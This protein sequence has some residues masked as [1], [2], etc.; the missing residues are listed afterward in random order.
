MREAA[1]VVAGNQYIATR[2]RKAGAKSVKILP[3]VVDLDRYPL[4]PATN[5]E[6]F[7]IGWIG[8]PT[9]AYNLQ[10]VRPALEAFC[11]SRSAR[12]VGVGSSSLDLGRVPLEVK[13]WVES[14]EVEEIR[15]FNVGIMPLINSP[16]ERGKNGFKL[17]QYMACAKPVIGS[18]VGVNRDI[19]IDGENGFCATTSD[20]WIHALERLWSDGKLRNRLGKAG[21]LRVEERYS[22]RVAAPQLVS[23]LRSVT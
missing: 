8:S 9:T 5:T 7:T 12:V 19:I 17:I 14:T 2:A 1:L 20:E 4:V 10:M 16:F 22:L 11:D 6:P 21:R 3:T 15:R 23:I 13:P 18:P